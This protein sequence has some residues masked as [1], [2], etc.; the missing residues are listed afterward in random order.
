MK[1]L[2]FTHHTRATFDID[3]NETVKGFWVNLVPCTFWKPGSARPDVSQSLEVDRG[4]PDGGSLVPYNRDENLALVSQREQLLFYKC[5]DAI[6]YLVKTRA[7]AV[8]VGQS[9]CGKTTQVP[10][11]LAEAIAGCF[12]THLQISALRR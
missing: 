6:L 10:Q 4:G 1:G 7:T 11:Y 3:R 5:R 2:L 9:G 12:C 8:L